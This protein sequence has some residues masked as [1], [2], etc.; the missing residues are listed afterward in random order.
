MATKVAGARRAPG[1]GKTTITVLPPPRS[2]LLNPGKTEVLPVLPPTAPLYHVICQK[3]N[4]TSRH[5]FLNID[6]KINIFHF[7]L[8]G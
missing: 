2:I 1:L 4:Q 5:T 6:L 3:N 7:Y 8:P